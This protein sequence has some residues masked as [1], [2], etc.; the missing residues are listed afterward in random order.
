VKAERGTPDQAPAR[1]LA[2]RAPQAF[3]R[4]IDI[5][6]VNSELAVRSNRL[7]GDADR[8]NQSVRT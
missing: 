1:I 7:E 4:M 2:Y 8:S 6:A 5:L 3:A